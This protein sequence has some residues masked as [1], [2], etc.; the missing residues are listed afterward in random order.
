MKTVVIFDTNFLINNTGK[1]Q[2]ILIDLEKKQIDVY[3]PE[4]VKEEY[5]NIQLRKLVE[6]YNKLENFDNLQKIIDLKYR[7][8]EEAIKII[9]DT[10]ANLFEK[11]FEG[12]LIKY[13]KEKMLERVLQRNKFKE[14]PFYNENNSSDK[15][16]KDTIILLTIMGFISIYE[17]EAVF[18]YI[19]SDNGFIKYKKDIENE[20]NEKLKKTITIIDGKDKNKVYQEL[21]ILQEQESNESNKEENIFAKQEIDIEEIREKIN[22]LMNT[23]T[24]IV[25][26]DYYGNPQ[27]EKRFEISNYINFEKTEKFL[28]NIDKIIEENIFRKEIL[29]ELFFET[30]EWVFSKNSIDVNT[31]KE[32]SDL[33]KIVKN[34]KYKEAFIN[35]ISQRIN[36]NKVSN[37]FSTE[38]DDELPF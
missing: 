31:I 16:F 30:E 11:S 20:I 7:K 15:G 19:T 38:S 21:N 23:F 5:I 37:M 28:D 24:S 6:T 18:Y 17:E 1:I 35:Y 33:Y 14:P 3:V 8:K 4:L 29:V 26:F 13:N 12:K 2:E 32:I 34:T 22:E 36:E 25:D 10:Y 9:E 27:E